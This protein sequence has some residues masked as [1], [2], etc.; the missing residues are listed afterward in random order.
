MEGLGVSV[1]MTVEKRKG[2]VM[3]AIYEIRSLIDECGS[4]VVG[5]LVSGLDIWEIA[6]VPK[7]LSNAECW[8]QGSA[9]TI[10]VI[11]KLQLSSLHVLLAVGSVCPNVVLLS[12]TGTLLMEVRILQKK[13]LLLHHIHQLPESALA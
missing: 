11:E 6:V 7:L 2:L 9:T 5:R 3:S 4:H 13:L 8:F 10:N 1:A 12:E